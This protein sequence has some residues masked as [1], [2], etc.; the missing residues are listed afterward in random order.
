MKKNRRKG[1]ILRKDIIKSNQREQRNTEGKNNFET[2]DDVDIFFKQ[3]D[4]V[5]LEMEETSEKDSSD[6]EEE[7]LPLNSAYDTDESDEDVN[8]FEGE[9]EEE[10]H[11]DN[12]ES[13]EDDEG[14]DSED[15]FNDEEEEAITEKWGK[16][17]ESFYNTEKDV[18]EDENAALEEEIEVKRLQKKRAKSLR[19]EDFGLLVQ[20]SDSPS[21]KEIK[22]TIPEGEHIIEQD[23]S[24]SV[25]MESITRDPNG[26]SIEEKL[27]IL[28]NESPEL[29]KLLEEFKEQVSEIR[30][31]L[32]PLLVRAQ[33]GEICT[34]EGISY[35]E[36]KLHLLL[37]Y[38]THIVF[39]LLLKS[40]GKS[41]KAHP[42]IDQ[43]ARIRTILER[44]RPLDQKLK[45]Q[46]DRLLLRATSGENNT[47]HI[48]GG[49][50]DPRRLKANLDGLM[51]PE[52][53]DA[54][55]I[56][57]TNSNVGKYKI[58]KFSEAHFQESKENA[59]EKRDAHL[60]KKL[61]S[62]RMLQEIEE[63]FGDFPEEMPNIG[64]SVD[65]VEDKEDIE[66]QQY[67]ES[68]LTRLQLTKNEKNRQKAKR[69]RQTDE[70]LENI[71]SFRD[72][73]D[74]TELHKTNGREGSRREGKGSIGNFLEQIS[75]GKG[76]SVANGR[77]FAGDDDLPYK[78]PEEELSK[79]RKQRP[80][81][82]MHKDSLSEEEI[83]EVEEDELYLDALRTK[84]E[85]AQRK[86]QKRKHT[87]V[88]PDAGLL[89]E[90]KKRAITNDIRSNRGLTSARKKSLKNPRTKLR[91]RY[92]RA[93]RSRRG[94]TPK[95]VSKDSPYAGETT[96]INRNA[97]RSVHL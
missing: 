44:L 33:N 2:G 59:R 78:D 5:G 86:Q 24:E 57:T 97:T 67:E 58:P 21:L 53:P 40:E 70:N 29:L 43:L 65:I 74:L 81:E 37:N 49:K 69:R 94:A 13:I 48:E 9:I 83:S 41:I 54:D 16:K 42:V 30:G 19:K 45:S 71:L 7:V 47:N 4:K 60:R 31:N 80:K 64:A 62:S 77:F 88:L 85:K 84:Q 35:L 6:Q 39:Y 89:I 32:H 75:T 93:V 10:N 87:V 11:S 18:E 46:I 73:E 55:T 52:N 3:R 63:E 51:D 72:F 90:G 79:K 27:Q 14:N 26:I 1:G 91:H 68:M 36:M 61:S 17:K 82:G 23:A 34:S 20:I 15:E 25:L 8:E 28:E 22:E 56:G 96:G 38:C 92:E 76:K 95:S 66:R 12:E 50:D